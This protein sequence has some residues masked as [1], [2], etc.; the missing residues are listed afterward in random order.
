MLLR[1][2]DVLNLAKYGNP[3]PDRKIVKTD[4]EWKE[5]P[6]PD[7][8][9]VTRQAGTERPFSSAMCSLFEPGIYA[10]LCGDN[11]LFDASEEFA[12]GTGWRSF[13][14]PVA[15]NV[16]AYR[17]DGPA[18]L[19]QANTER[20]SMRF[21]E[22][23]GRSYNYEEHIRDCTLRDHFDRSAPGAKRT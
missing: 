20:K 5:Q 2:P 10:S 8:Y 17:F 22:A 23:D 13:T 12:S 3:A 6:T 18:F 15:A 14:R 9:H 16:I 19:P 4:A 1:W 21:R 11:V 7:E